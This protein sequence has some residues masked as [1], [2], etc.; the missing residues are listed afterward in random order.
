MPDSACLPVFLNTNSQDTNKYHGCY[1]GETSVKRKIELIPTS[2]VSWASGLR[3][4]FLNTGETR[5]RRNLCALM[6]PK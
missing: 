1:L 4:I 2:F 6:T 5:L 3:N